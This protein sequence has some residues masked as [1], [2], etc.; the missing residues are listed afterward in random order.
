MKNLSLIIWNFT[1]E[2][3]MNSYFFYHVKLIYKFTCN[4]KN[5]KDIIT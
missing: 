3:G 4:V 1:T 5:D 2:Y